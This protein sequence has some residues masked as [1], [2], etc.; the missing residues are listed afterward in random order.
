MKKLIFGTVFTLLLVGHLFAQ[1]G[2]GPPR[3]KVE[4]FKVGFLTKKLELTAEE[5]QRFWPVYNKYSDELEKNRMGMKNILGDHFV[6]LDNLSPAE[7][8]KA[9]VDMQALR[10]QEVEILKQY[11]IEF[12]KV[13]P[14][15][16]VVKLFVAEHEFKRELL[17]Q[18]RDQRRR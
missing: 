18:L 1:R 10:Q 15:Q 14:A 3:E 11:T 6:K 16:K 8:E 2:D 12:K 4:A 5:A 7:A 13:L 9:L 17:K